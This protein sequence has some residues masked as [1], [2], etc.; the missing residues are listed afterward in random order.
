MTRRAR[1]LLSKLLAVAAIIGVLAFTWPRTAARPTGNTPDHLL[2]Y[3]AAGLR[4]PVQEIVTAYQ[5]AYGITI[6]VQYG[7][8]GT[9]LSNLDVA[10]RGD[11]YLAADAHHIELA[12]ER[13]LA[14][15]TIPVARQHLTLAVLHGNPKGIRALADLTR[16]D[17]RI[18]LANPEVASAGKAIRTVLEKARLWQDV[19]PRVTVFKPTINEVTNDLLLGAVDVGAIWDPL[20]AQHAEL[21]AIPLPELTA[22]SEAIR[23][24][25]LTSTKTPTRALHFARFLSAR[26]RGQAVFSRLGYQVE[27][28]DRWQEAPTL[29]LY[30]GGV[31]RVAVQ[32]TLRDFEQ[33][34]GCAVRVVYN[35]CGVLVAQIKSLADGP[36]FPDI[37]LTCDASY[38]DPVQERFGTRTLLSET[39]IVI[40]VPKANPHGIRS[41]G[42]L[43]QAGLKVGLCNAEQSTLGALTQRLLKNL[44]IAEQVA[45]NVRSQ[46]PTADLLVAQLQTGSLDA[47]VVY[48]ANATAV[49]AQCA[50]IPITGPGATAVQSFAIARQAEHPRLAERLLAALRSTTSRERY[51]SAGFRWHTP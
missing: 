23:I 8:S 41:L 5:R 37:F 29:T 25:V 13:G 19:Q 40:L 3:C 1:Q 47:V 34:E 10:R 32:E 9:L 42:D 4:E 50:A 16:T 21:D 11:L 43:T 44:G 38:L 20:V 48:Q 17:V 6:D 26:D 30:S 33:R 7:G 18:A 22:Q 46:T 24:A 15:E 39:D 14:A 49:L 12:V 28:G 45:T 51:Q 2:L 35:G 36:A 27:G 31:N